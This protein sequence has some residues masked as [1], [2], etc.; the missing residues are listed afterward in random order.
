[1]GWH[2]AA[3]NLRYFRQAEVGFCRQI[4][5][6]AEKARQKATP[7]EHWYEREQAA[8]WRKLPAHA[9]QEEMG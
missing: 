2:W 4:G 8:G 7:G 1:M 9:A 3:G 5:N 6:H